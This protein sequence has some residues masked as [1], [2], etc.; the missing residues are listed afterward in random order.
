MTT[1]KPETI[2]PADC[3]A[4]A[5]QVDNLTAEVQDYAAQVVELT[6]QVETLTAEKAAI[7]G[8]LAE[9]SA[10]ARGRS[11]WLV[12]TPFAGYSGVTAGVTFRQGKAFL[13]DDD[14]GKKTAEYIA[15]EFG[16]SV[17]YVEDWQDLPA[18]DAK[19]IGRSLIDQLTLPARR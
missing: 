16:Y 6:A 5:A 9:V 10:K 15:A 8:Q 1:K 3:E 14:D 17:Q 2:A 13:P 4:L 7:A 18:Q 11:G 19:P 12:S